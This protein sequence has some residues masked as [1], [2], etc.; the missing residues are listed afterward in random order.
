M[1]HPVPI[2]NP[3]T[4]AERACLAKAVG[5]AEGFKLDTKS[6]EIDVGVLQ[7]QQKLH[8]SYH[9][10]NLRSQLMNITVFT[11]WRCEVAHE[12]RSCLT[13]SREIM[14]AKGM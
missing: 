14:E 4:P 13:Q 3:D 6:S 12:G 1:D 11:D 2:A 10:F 8:K 9:I 7:Q 5:V